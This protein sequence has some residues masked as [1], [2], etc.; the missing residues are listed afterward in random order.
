METINKL[1]ISLCGSSYVEGEFKLKVYK[2]D[3]EK[4]TPKSITIRDGIRSVRKSRT[5]LNVVL[6]EHKNNT[7]DS[8]SFYCFCEDDRVEE[9]TEMLVEKLKERFEYNERMYLSAK[10]ALE[11]NLKCIL[12][13]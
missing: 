12:S 1:T 8:I 5:E 13:V 10:E 4:P 2:Y 6:V 7:F 3:V 9:L 11:G